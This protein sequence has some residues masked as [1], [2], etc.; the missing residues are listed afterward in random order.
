M[1]GTVSVELRWPRPWPTW[2]CHCQVAQKVGRRVGDCEHPKRATG[3]SPEPPRSPKRDLRFSGGE[4]QVCY[5]SQRGIPGWSLWTLSE[6][7]NWIYR[8]SQCEPMFARSSMSIAVAPVESTLAFFWVQVS[9]CCNCTSMYNIAAFGALVS[10]M[11]L[12][13]LKYP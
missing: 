1:T 9:E 12:K 10:P 3:S 2:S 6:R 11:N 5:V 8:V 13:Y 4:L 7:G